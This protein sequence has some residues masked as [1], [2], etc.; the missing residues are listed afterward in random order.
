MPYAEALANDLRMNLKRAD[1]DT[2][3]NSFNKKIREAVT[4]KIPNIVIIGGKEVESN[5]VTL[6]RYCTD[7]QI[8]MSR[9]AFVERINKLEKERIMDNFAD[10]IVE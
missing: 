3:D 5:T 1:I 4:H 9:D 2:S 10:V 6:R 8:T 7:K